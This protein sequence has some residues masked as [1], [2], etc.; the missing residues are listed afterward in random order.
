MAEINWHAVNNGLEFLTSAVSL[1]N[2]GEVKYAAVHL[3]ASI[4]ILLKV[5]LAREHWALVVAD[6][7]E[8]QRTT[9][10][11]G[12]FKSATIDQVVERLVKIANVAISD[13]DR[14][15][16]RSLN[17]TRNQIAHFA[18]VGDNPLAT[19]ATVA[20]AMEMLLRFIEKELAPGAP[21]RERKLIDATFSE[22]MEQIREIDVLVKERMNSLKPTIDQAEVPVVACPDCQKDSYVCDGGPGRCLFC[23]YQFAGDVVAEDYAS[24]ILHASKY[25]A[26]KMRSEWPVSS[27]HECGADALVR[28]VLAMAKVQAEVC[29]F[30]CGYFGNYSDLDTCTNCGE[31]MGRSEMTVCGSCFEYFASKD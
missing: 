28:G 13:E 16:I 10:D 7:R 12:D 21:D 5:R 19:Q 31:V 15:R 18:L 27:C 3:S 11:T 30:S 8:A 29:C 17:R 25:L 6:P 1:L 23:S 4:E 14:K 9:Y 26:A 24:N 22:V 20:R 2:D